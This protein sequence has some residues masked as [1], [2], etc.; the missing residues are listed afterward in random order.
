MGR[1]P[2][3]VCR[4]HPPAHSP[5]GRQDSWSC[6]GKTP[7]WLYSA[8]PCPRDVSVCG[9]GQQTFSQINLRFMFKWIAL[10]IVKFFFCFRARRMHLD[11]ERGLAHRDPGS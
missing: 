5:L 1:G 3:E 4:D 9:I 8:S 7:L 10:G 11:E 6:F 2:G